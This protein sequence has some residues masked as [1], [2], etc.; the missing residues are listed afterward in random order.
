M[1]VITFRGEEIYI[2][3]FGFIIPF[4]ICVLIISKDYDASIL[5]SILFTIWMVEINAFYRENL[6]ESQ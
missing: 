3:R 6:K 4:I 5:F 1:V 2:D